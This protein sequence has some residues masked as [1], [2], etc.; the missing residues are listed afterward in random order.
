MLS[1][2]IEIEGENNQERIPELREFNGI[3]SG[4]DH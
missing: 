1:Y 3:V 4:H 2:L